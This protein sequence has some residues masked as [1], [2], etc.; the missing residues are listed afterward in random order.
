V[1]AISFL[2][3]LG[4]VR[5]VVSD[6]RSVRTTRDGSAARRAAAD[7]HAAACDLV[8]LTVAGMPLPILGVEPPEELDNRLADVM[9]G[10]IDCVAESESRLRPDGGDRDD[11]PTGPGCGSITSSEADET[12]AASDTERVRT[13]GGHRVVPLSR[14]GPAAANWYVLCDVVASTAAAVATDCRT[15][16]DRHSVNGSGSVAGEWA[17]V[18]DLLSDLAAL[19]DY[20]V[21]LAR[22][23]GVPGRET[24][25]GADEVRSIAER[26]FTETVRNQ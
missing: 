13:V 22:W 18:A 5:A 26:L 9:T 4:R 24:V 25:V 2:G 19:V 7:A 3:A 21:S 14:G 6:R 8:D 23:V 1:R 20:H 12:G 11:V 15:L 10:M 17:D 16:A